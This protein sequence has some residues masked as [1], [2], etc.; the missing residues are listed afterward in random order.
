VKKRKKETDI[1]IVF[2]VSLSSSS[3]SISSSNSCCC[4][5]WKR[6]VQSRYSRRY[7]GKHCQ[8]AWVLIIV[9]ACRARTSYLAANSPITVARR[10]T[11]RVSALTMAITISLRLHAVN[12]LR[13]AS[14][15][16]NRFRDSFLLPVR[17]GQLRWRLLYCPVRTDCGIDH[18]GAFTRA[19]EKVFFCPLGRV[20]M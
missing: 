15:T 7:E 13:H 9:V 14:V 10:P 19:L 11:R 1:H 3:S 5:S 18:Y 20:L 4:S 8:W 12:R 6:R 16:L 2:V 17:T